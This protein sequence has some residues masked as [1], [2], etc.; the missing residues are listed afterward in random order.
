MTGAAMT[1]AVL[2]Y[3]MYGHEVILDFSIPPWLL[4]T[5]ERVAKSKDVGLDYVVL[6]PGEAVCASCAASRSEQKIADYAP[7]RELYL[8]S[9]EAERHVL[10]D[11]VSEAAAIAARIRDALNAGT[12]YLS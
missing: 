1:V 3:A 2:P 8:S 10:A 9:Y 7:Y 6:R 12:F 4:E 5:A 11:D